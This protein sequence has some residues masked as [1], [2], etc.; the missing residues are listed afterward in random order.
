[1]A[2]LTKTK[3]CPLC[4][5]PIKSHYSFCKDCEYDSGYDETESSVKKIKPKNK[6]EF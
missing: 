6:K 4:G 1:M 5:A 2:S 3:K